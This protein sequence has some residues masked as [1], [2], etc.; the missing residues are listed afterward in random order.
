MCFVQTTRLPNMSHALPTV[1]I[2]PE[3]ATTRDAAFWRIIARL[4][5]EI[6]ELEADVVRYRELAQQALAQQ[7][8]L[9]A[10]NYRLRRS[11]EAEAAV[12]GV[13]PR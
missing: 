4:G 13:Y 7:H 8:A 5:D 10:E 9:T 2:L 6:A 1:G 3:P 11:A 12:T